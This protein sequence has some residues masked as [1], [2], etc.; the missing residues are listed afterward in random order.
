MLKR[1]FKPK[2]QH[3]NPAV[4]Q[5]A[6]AHLDDETILIEIANTDNNTKVCETAIQRIS[7]TATLLKI[8]PPQNL[9]SILNQQFAKLIKKEVAQLDF[10]PGIAS[11]L[12]RIN[13][14]ELNKTVADHARDIQLREAAISLIEEKE[15]TLLAHYALKDPSS[16][17]RHMT[18]QRLNDETLIRD[19][20]KQLGKKDK[21][22]A[23]TLRNQLD[24]LEAD[25]LKQR[26]IK[27][28]IEWVEQVGHNDQCQRNQAQLNTLKNRWNQLANVRDEDVRLFSDACAK[29]QMRIEDWQ[30][31]LDSLKPLIHAK[32]S[33]C[34]LTENFLTRLNQRQ[35]LSELEATELLETLDTFHQDW[36]QLELLPKEL[37]TPLNDRFHQTLNQLY[38]RVDFLQ[39]NTRFTAGLEKVIHKAETQLQNPPLQAG[40]I[41]ALIADWERQKQP[42]DPRLREEYQ[43]QFSRLSNQLNILYEKQ[44]QN[45]KEELKKIQTWLNRIETSLE[46]DQLNDSD[47]LQIEIKKALGKLINTPKQEKLAL[48]KRLQKTLPKIQELKGWRHWGTDQARKELIAEAIALKEIDQDANT[49]AAAVRKLRSRWKKLGEIDPASGRK[50]WKDFD[51]AC[52][53]A[54]ALC[55][56]HFDAEERQR[57]KN[58]EHR[59]RICK[60]YEALESSTNWDS[61]DWRTIDKQARTLQ[62]R[63][64]KANPVSRQHWKSILGRYKAAQSAVE[65]H[66]KNERRINRNKREALIEKLEALHDHDDLAKAI[67]AAKDAQRAWQ[68]TVTDTRAVEQ[69]LWK[70][71]RAA[72]DA[73]F[74]RAK[75]K[76]ETVRSEINAV[77]EK[78][79]MLCVAAEQLATQEPISSS[80][81][82]KL[83]SQWEEIK[84]VSDKQANKLE[85]RFDKAMQSIQKI[86][87]KKYWE[88]QLEQ[89]SSL[90][91]RHD[92]LE[93]YEKAIQN[94]GDD[95]LIESCQQQWLDM[96]NNENPAL[97]ARFEKARQKSLKHNELEAHAESRASLLLDLEILLELKS[98]PELAERRMQKQVDRLADAMAHKDE[99][100]SQLEPA[101]KR[102]K[103]YC[104]SG[105]VPSEYVEKF[106]SRLI[107][108]VAN[109]ES[110]L[111]KLIED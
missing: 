29:A 54:Y 56:A 37:E 107:P 22:V 5:R 81:I 59:E 38:E 91:E 108:V 11:R 89:L 88:Q 47:I 83:R 32:E 43:N 92:L 71:F 75:E 17:I 2:W 27:S 86:T 94:N 19:T 68:P 30:Q 4:R 100:D 15:Q 74:A 6:I 50:R 49:R 69:K 20:L 57:Q 97:E 36:D 67:Q 109:L 76:Q 98:P 23:Q 28:I 41:E 55:Q 63:W 13:S 3:K 99:Q 26:E 102:I 95:I 45:E 9:Q 85:R 72:A 84:P 25:R 52:S 64:R 42:E 21:R 105:A 33:Q 79:T 1:F 66:L 7:S 77:L 87:Q 96:R 61:P 106:S 35:R 60:D 44:K 34:T 24:A 48:E 70:R 82:S 73:I 104:E 65:S 103:A 80:E 101:L 58:L 62:N 39:K 16:K 12:Q 53:E 51:K 18:A 31:K 78:K 46:K 14:P 10:H 90:L 110:K 40:F 93:T 111:T 8:T